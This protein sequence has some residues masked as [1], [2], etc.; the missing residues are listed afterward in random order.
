VRAPKSCVL[1]ACCVRQPE[2]KL[3][4]GVERINSYTEA[5]AGQSGVSSFVP[6]TPP[7]IPRQ[8]GGDLLA[9]NARCQGAAHIEEGGRL[10]SW[11]ACF[12]SEK[13]VFTAACDSRTTAPRAEATGGWTTVQS[14]SRHAP[15]VPAYREGFNARPAVPL[16]LRGRCFRCDSKRHRAL[17]CRD[18]VTPVRCNNCW[19]SG[20]RE[21]DCKQAKIYR[22]QGQ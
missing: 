14:R 21:H 2:S 6:E 18:P 5:A 13:E 7:E 16:W 3:A 12:P 1:C 9:F 19:R 15:A 11:R 20:H 8:D 17:A 22:L 10:G 4:A